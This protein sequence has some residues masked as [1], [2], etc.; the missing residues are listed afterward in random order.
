[1]D[2]HAMFCKFSWKNLHCQG[3]R[4]ARVQNS[5]EGATEGIG[6]VPTSTSHVHLICE[7]V[8]ENQQKK[9]VETPWALRSLESFW[10]G[11]SHSGSI[12]V[13][14]KL[15]NSALCPNLKVQTKPPLFVTV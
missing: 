8:I 14:A 6:R 10:A 11:D 5:A 15:H 7:L 13:G 9:H 2:G 4:C 12:W 3:P 1:M